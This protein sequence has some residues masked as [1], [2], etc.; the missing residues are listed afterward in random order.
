MIL[1]RLRVFLNIMLNTS[2]NATRVVFSREKGI[3]D[4]KL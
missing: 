4:T 3:N 2:S 1:K